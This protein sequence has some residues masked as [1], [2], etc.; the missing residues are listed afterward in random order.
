MEL[1]FNTENIIFE[2]IINSSIALDAAQIRANLQLLEDVSQSIRF[3]TRSP[4][5]HASRLGRETLLQ[6][7]L[8]LK[9]GENTLISLLNEAPE[10]IKMYK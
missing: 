4:L 7:W 5:A 2:P 10:V 8:P 3:Y 6:R 9:R 1:F